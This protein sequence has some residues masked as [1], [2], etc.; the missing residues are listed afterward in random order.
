MKRYGLFSKNSNEAI[1]QVKSSH[2][3]GAIL[4]FAAQKRLELEKFHK[5]F[6]VREV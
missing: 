2:L 3:D 6:E 1:N 5:L 4:F